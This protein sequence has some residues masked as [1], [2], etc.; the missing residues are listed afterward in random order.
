MVRKHCGKRRNMR[1]FSFSQSVYKRL[2]SQGRQKV[3]LCGNGLRVA[4]YYS[5]KNISSFQKTPF[6]PFPNNPLF[7][8][9]Y[10]SSPFKTLWEKEKLL[11]TSNFSFS[12][13]V[14]YPFGEL[15]AIFIKLKIV[16]C[17][18][19]QFGKV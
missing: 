17:K 1:I 6:N 16:V 15:S 18:L 3:S 12:N 11:V 19:F 4:F 14:F 5:R 7:L 13:S 8:P 9:V 10:S 2:D